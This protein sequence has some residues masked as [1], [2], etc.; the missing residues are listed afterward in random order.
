MGWLSAL[1]AA[2]GEAAAA[3]AA[4]AA[5]A[6]TAMG[7][8]AADVAMG[9]GGPTAGGIDIGA[10]G[11]PGYGGQWPATPPA[12]GPYGGYGG[13]G[14]TLGTPPESVGG[15]QP[16]STKE[17]VDISKIV[18]GVGDEMRKSQKQQ[19]NSVP[20]GVVNPPNVPVVVAPSP[21]VNP[22]PWPSIQDFSRNRLNR[23]R[24]GV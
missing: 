24:G 9:A 14:E 5:A 7:A 12:A 6:D 19:P 16:Q 8:S 2:G 1:G 10:V 18:K 20:S 3:D 13:F 17:G 22:A 21:M 23:D 11:T 4:T 15:Y